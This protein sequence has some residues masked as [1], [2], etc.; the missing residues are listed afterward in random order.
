MNSNLCAKREIYVFFYNLLMTCIA[1]KI[2]L[3]SSEPYSQAQVRCD[4][5]DIGMESGQ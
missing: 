5:S 3:C 1:C 2:F 4:E